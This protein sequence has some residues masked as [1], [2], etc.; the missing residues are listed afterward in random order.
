MHASTA[1]DKRSN[2]RSNESST[3]AGN[4]QERKKQARQGL[5]VANMSVS[6]DIGNLFQRFGGNP[7]RYQEVARDDDAKHAAS[8]WPLLSAVDIAQPEQVPG[9]GRPAPAMS[10]VQALSTAPATR[11]VGG[12]VFD[13]GVQPA[14]TEAAT[15][16]ADEAKPVSNVRSAAAELSVANTPAAASAE[17]GNVTLDPLTSALPRSPLFARGHR[18]AM[19]P[20]PVDAA[21]QAASRFSPPPQAAAA[22][23]DAEATA[24]QP[25]QPTAGIAAVVAPASPATLRTSATAAATAAAAT[26]TVFAAPAAST[27]SAADPRAANDATREAAREPHTG[28]FANRKQTFAPAPITG[29]TETVRAPAQT[30]A[31]RTARTTAQPQ[32]QPQ[33]Q[34]RP[35]PLPQSQP[36]PAPQA[37][38]QRSILSGL[39][40]AQPAHETEPSPQPGTR[41]LT[42]VFARLAGAARRDDKNPGGERS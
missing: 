13:A 20:P 1:H 19:M 12:G 40:A 25:A 37:S 42:T 27:V 9:A 24:R 5:G 2:E 35:N 26:P 22:A 17:D 3:E 38:A 6:D 28:F 30:E 39:F 36:Q 10:A 11:P 21:R 29:A 34:S 8:R 32:P 4:E 15:E 31:Q 18:H 16:A 41:D 7:D 23:S 33:P 14:A